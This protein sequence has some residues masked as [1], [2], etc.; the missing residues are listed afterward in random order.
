ML[1]FE[2]VP[3]KA[4]YP[5]AAS[6]EVLAQR[7]SQ[8]LGAI[9]GVTGA[10]VTTNLPASDGL[11]GQFNN[12]M[13]TPDGK[14]FEAQLHGVGTDFFRVF[15]IA[16]K[17]GRAFSRDDTGGSEPVAVV[18]R[19]L[20]DR[21]Y[22]GDAIG[23]TLLVGVSNGPDQPVRIVG[24]V[25]DTYQR[26]PLQPRE[27]MLY[28]PLAQMP[29]TTMD[30]FLG[31]EP[32]RFALRGHGSPADWRAGVE[33]A[34]AEI[35]PGQPIAHLRSMRSIVDQT[36]ANAHL[37]ML[38]V[39]LFATLSLLLAVAGMYAVM[40]VA[41]AAR[42]REFGVRTALGASPS[43]MTRLVL[44]GG[45]SQVAVGLVL[46]VGMALG[47][48]RVMASLSMAVAMSSI[49]RI[50]TFDPLAL[51]GVCGVLALSGL[52]ACLLPALRAGRV[53]PMSVLR[54]D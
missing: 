45:M 54:G 31:L 36:T 6:V 1:T 3:V 22:N 52:V 29:A 14:Q 49:G 27:P 12:G 9:S 53:R 46:G 50:G 41:V 40:A 17:Q 28:L 20:A 47:A 8:R 30:I 38:M 23:K 16:L 15:S 19:D 24:V 34:V 37:S 13:K 35:A 44:R 48:S 10:A 43:R 51:V 5:D 42:E 39:G 21:Y 7:L 2:L 26:G 4:H 25:A 18:S 33:Q 32:L 11:Y